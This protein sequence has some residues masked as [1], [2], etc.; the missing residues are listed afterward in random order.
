MKASAS[1]ATI[2]HDE[3]VLRRTAS[4]GSLRVVRKLTQAGPTVEDAIRD[5]CLGVDQLLAQHARRRAAPATWVVRVMHQQEA[6]YK[7]I[8]A[9][10]L[11]ALAHAREE[12][13]V[14]RARLADAQDAL[15]APSVEL[16]QLNDRYNES[17]LRRE[18]AESEAR[19]LHEALHQA[20]AKLRDAEA[21]NAKGA[22]EV[23]WLRRQ[24]EMASS[25]E[26]KAQVY[27]ED[28]QQHVA[29]LRA[30]LDQVKDELAQKDD[31]LRRLSLQ[32]EFYKR[33]A[34][35]SEGQKLRKEMRAQVAPGLIFAQLEAKL[36]IQQASVWA[37]VIKV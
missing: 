14:A 1:Q 18:R 21:R 15:V 13:T 35:E 6:Q 28:A 32:L 29:Q 22:D 26:K 5:S 36:R 23:L 25:R 12:A 4:A 10:A 27:G 24:L 33:E 37:A 9:D 30:D 19:V 20:E 16:R 7:R 31:D 8:L 2:Q 3:P 11:S 17:D 34:S